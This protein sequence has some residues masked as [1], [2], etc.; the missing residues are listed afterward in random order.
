MGLPIPAESARIRDHLYIHMWATFSAGNY[1]VGELSA[2]AVRGVARSELFSSNAGRAYWAAVR[3]RA[4]STNEGKY[5]RF[6]RIVD[7]EY[8]KV[9]ASDVR[10]AD[11]VI[12][13]DNAD[14]SA[15]NWRSGLRRSA[16]I[17]AALIPLKVLLELFR[18]CTF[19]CPIFSFAPI[20]TLR[21]FIST[22]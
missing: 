22:G 19:S 14:H 2:A 8:Q 21:L 16:L 3:E 1:V 18:Q 15:A 6:A 17:S 5:L 10:V 20:V 9:I 7:E 4:L 12:V 11:P 13:T